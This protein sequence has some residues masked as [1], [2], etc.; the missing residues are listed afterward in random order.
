[1]LA[2]AAS[3]VLGAAAA[4][5]GGSV[6]GGQIGPYWESPLQVGSG[7][8]G[9]ELLNASFGMNAVGDAV[10]GWEHWVQATNNDRMD[11]V[12]R[13]AGATSWSAPIDL[14]ERMTGQFAVDAGGGM[15]L[16]ATSGK[17]SEGNSFIETFQRP[18][19]SGAWQG[20]AILSSR[21]ADYGG[22]LAVDP[23]G[24][25]AAGWIRRYPDPYQDSAVLSYRSVAAGE[26]EHDQVVSS[27]YGVDGGPTVAIDTAGNAVAVWAVLQPSAGAV[28]QASFRPANGTWQEPVDVAGPFGGYKYIG[29]QVAFDSFGNATAV[30]DDETTFG[31]GTCVVQSAYRPAGR[32]WQAAGVIWQA[33]TGVAGCDGGVSLA[34]DPAGRA[35]ACWINNGVVLAATRAATTTPWQTETVM[36]IAVDRDRAVPHAYVAIDPAGNA[37]AAW[38]NLGGSVEASL[39]PAASGDWQP[40]TK[41][42]PGWTLA[43]LAMDARSNAVAVWQDGPSP[44]I[45]ASDLRASGPVLED[46]SQ[47]TKGLVQTPILFTVKP[48]PWAAPLADQP[49]WNF[50]DGGSATGVQ[51][52]HIYAQSGT[53]TVSVS[54]ADTSGDSST[55][56]RTI[57]IAAS[58][59][60][61]LIR[62]RL[63][64]QPRVGA[65]LICLPGIWQGTQ[66]IGYRY[67]WLRNG[68]SIATGSRHHLGKH[69]AATLMACR[70]HTTNAAGG[71]EAT[72]PTV[73]VSR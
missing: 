51:V 36:T 26:W 62:P 23:G 38:S 8:H 2:V 9:D 17:P 56:N 4:S 68:R 44:G 33:G 20:P 50:G 52:S 67:L 1:V 69:D 47:P 58:I 27:S 35:V 54:Q 12:S 16:L 40:P 14:G 32:D 34:V 55:A 3:V 7:G 71:G 48:E 21:N 61:D 5:A 18:A 24:D 65:T 30:W 53:Y 19:A 42:G 60:T 73:R 41:V 70:V 28:I 29:I 46:I 11:V 45:D 13:V 64:G 57:T 63:R 10:I 39:R 49:R 37:V 43:G 72:S 22:S 66:P 6:P 59:P 31:Q 25:A 15:T